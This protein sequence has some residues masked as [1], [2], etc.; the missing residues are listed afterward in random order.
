MP[1][2]ILLTLP[3]AVS[4][5]PPGYGPAPGAYGTA[6]GMQP[7]PQSATPSQMAPRQAPSARGGAHQGP[8]RQAPT[9]LQ[10][11][12]DKLLAF[13][14]QKELPNKLQIAAFLDREIAPYFDFDYMAKWAAGSAY[15]R[16]READRKALAA[17][18]EASFLSGLG[19]H[20][21]GYSGQQVRILRPRMASRGS[22]NVEVGILRGD[23]PPAKL[24]FRMYERDG[25]WKVYDVAA[26]GRSASAYY[27]T[28]FQ[29]MNAGSAP[30]MP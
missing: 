29:R 14:S 17:R 9:T 6:P 4:A 24:E 23:A 16:M 1:L 19:T 13:L 30:A 3:V 28:L 15:E 10:E 12:I 11:G 7:L 22:V 5:Q 20:L 18:L 8:L 21:A 26:Q 27:R 2:A 25:A